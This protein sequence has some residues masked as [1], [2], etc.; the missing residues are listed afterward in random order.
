MSNLGRSFTPGDATAAKGSV[1]CSQCGAA[2]ATGEKFC[3]A[4]GRE[5]VAPTRIRAARL[6]NQRVR[7]GVALMLSLLMLAGIV[8]FAILWRSEIDARQQR[9]ASIAQLNLSQTRLTAERD[10]LKRDLTETRAVASRRAAV[11]VKVEAALAFVEPLLSSVDELQSITGKMQGSRDSYYSASSVLKSDLIELAN[12][13]IRD[14]CAYY[15]QA[16]LIDEIN[17]EI[18]SVD[19]YASELSGHDTSYSTAGDRFDGQASR[20]TDALRKLKAQLTTV[21]PE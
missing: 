15:Y 5:V 1:I 9:D 10:S 8:V 13:L 2:L 20:F 3:S 11:L 17:G 6:F 19:Y 21:L 18:G 4:C 7:V 12:C 14:A 16:N